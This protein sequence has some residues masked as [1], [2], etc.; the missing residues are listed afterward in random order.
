V[1]TLRDRT[2][3]YTLGFAVLVALAVVGALA[4]AMLPAG[5]RLG[6]D[7]ST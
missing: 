2:G 6:P 7:H 3:S 1:A 4:I 5:R